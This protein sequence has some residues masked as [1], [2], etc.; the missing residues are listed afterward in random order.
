[1][2]PDADPGGPKTYGSYGSGSAT[3]PPTLMYF[4]C[5]AT[6]V[7][8]TCPA[9]LAMAT[10]EAS[11]WRIGGCWRLQLLIFLTANLRPAQGIMPS[12]L[13]QNQVVY[14]WLLLLI[15]LTANLTAAQGIM[16]SAV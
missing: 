5:L 12:T 7:T 13:R 8:P 15:V 9:L 10:L 4:G 16:P 14:H 11:T 6:Y 1:M 3:L 2:D